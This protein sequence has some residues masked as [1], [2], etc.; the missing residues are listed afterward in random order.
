MIIF[1]AFRDGIRRV[2]AAPAVLAGV[3]I[4]TLL[5]TLPLGL[6]LRSA[7]RAHLGDSVAADTVASGV[8]W[9]WWQE[10]SAQATGLGGTFSAIGHRRGRRAG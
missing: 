7:L 3:L 5:A 9:D 6:A 10:F 2:N 8:N 1:N 4:A